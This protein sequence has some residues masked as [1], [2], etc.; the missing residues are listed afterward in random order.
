M[1]NIKEAFTPE[2]QKERM[3]RAKRM[4]LYVGIFS[5]VMLFAG[6]TSAY[7]VSMS[8]GFWVNL[9]LPSAFWI[10]TIFI[11]L[12]S[13]TMILAFKA[14]KNNQVAQVKIY[15]IV[16]LVLALV[17]TKSQ[18]TGWS[19]LME[20][21]NYATGSNE[22]VNGVYGVNYTFLYAGEELVYE[23]G[24]FYLPSDSARELPLKTKIE[25]SKNTSSSFMYI[26]TALHL[27]HLVGGFLY[28]I[29]L[30]IGAFKN[31]YNSE[32][33]LRIQLGGTYWHFLAGLWVYL[34]LFLHFIH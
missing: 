12:S 24:E 25:Q 19:Q 30:L 3:S 6:F 23:N 15:L 7:V 29:A 28:L 18:F 27:I 21:G 32:N 8:D 26:L 34:L 9:E 14:A 13:I 4:L 22:T 33:Y 1:D 10:S 20:T 2:E 11:A 17:F 5:I 31:K 16:T